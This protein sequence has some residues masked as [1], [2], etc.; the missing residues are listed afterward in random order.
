VVV[1]QLCLLLSGVGLESM[2]G[3][4]GDCIDLK[5]GEAAFNE[6]LRQGYRRSLQVQW[7]VF[8]CPHV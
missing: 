1:D 8:V 5:G 7:K 4:L 3:V 6:T 2:L